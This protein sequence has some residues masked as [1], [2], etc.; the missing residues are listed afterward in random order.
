[1]AQEDLLNW[2]KSLFA[3]PRDALGLG[4]PKQI[5]VEYK[6]PYV[7]ATERFKSFIIDKGF[8]GCDDGS[9]KSLVVAGEYQDGDRVISSTFNLKNFEA[10]IVVQ[11]SQSEDGMFQDDEVKM[12]L[13][14][15]IGL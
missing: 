6:F 11:V 9:L 8:R 7:K 13:L 5:R 3:T 15:Q 2:N 4:S 14:E 12:A 10:S 1:M